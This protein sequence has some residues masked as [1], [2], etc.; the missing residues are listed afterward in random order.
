MKIVCGVRKGCEKNLRDMWSS[1]FVLRQ[2]LRTNPGLIW[3]EKHVDFLK[4]HVA[5]TPPNRNPL[6]RLPNTPP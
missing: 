5:I 3:E 1:V 6:V 2:I 4:R